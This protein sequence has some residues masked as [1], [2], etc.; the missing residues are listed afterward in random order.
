VAEDIRF[1][2]TA[3]EVGAV[4]AFKR[5]R[6]EVLN[7]EKQLDRVAKQGKM[8]STALKDSANILGPEFAILG[9][10]IDHITGALADVKNASLAAKASLITL[11]AVGSYEVS[12]MIN[13]WIWQTEAWKKANEEA[14]KGLTSE[15]EYRN[16]LNQDYF[17]LEMKIIEQAFTE[18]QRLAE[19]RDI[20]QQKKEERL[21]AEEQLT[22][23]KRALQ[24]ALANDL[25]EFGKEDNAINEAAVKL[26][27]EKVKLL[28]EQLQLIDKAIVGPSE[29]EL[30]L[31]NRIAA[32]QAKEREMKAGEKETVKTQPGPLQAQQQRFIT[33]G[34]GG[35]DIDRLI[36]IAKQQQALAQKDAM[37]TREIRKTLWQIRDKFPDE[38]FK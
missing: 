9:D 38:V 20:E 26:S 3:D 36:E 17:D 7:N 29:R 24:A 1:K 23:D 12:T 28:N 11:V 10:R 8:T 35:R 15:Q 37:E 34:P 13:D 27:E 4:N 6:S 21:L 14:I 19:L 33:R 25:L 2:I 18:E 16:K 22:K 5:F 31:Q 32:K 30:E